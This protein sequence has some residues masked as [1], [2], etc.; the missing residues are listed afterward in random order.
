MTWQEQARELSRDAKRKV[1]H[2]GADASAYISNSYKGVHLKCFRCGE[3]LFEPHS[4]RTLKDIIAFKRDAAGAI[5]NTV[6]MPK[7]ALPLSAAPDAAI[8]WLLRGGLMPETA[9]HIYG[10]RWEDALK[11]VLIPIYT[12][13]KL[14]GIL[15]RAVF[16]ERPK[17]IMLQGKPSLFSQIKYASDCVV[18]VEDVLSCIAISRAGVSAIAALGTTI[19]LQDAAR[20]AEAASRV[21]IWTDPDKA[22]LAARAKMC[23]KLELVGAQC[24]E[25][26]SESDP[27]ALTAE[28]IRQ[29]I[30]Q[31]EVSRRL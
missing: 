18:L 8:A 29:K 10:M 31:A 24:Y 20:I 9:E 15:G 23:A 7:T 30:A 25:V 17:Y 5:R 27:K 12:D 2:C 28:R 13:D 16:N 6:G 19:T 4:Q 22:G 21:V 11:R 1:P 3:R 14:S 26:Y